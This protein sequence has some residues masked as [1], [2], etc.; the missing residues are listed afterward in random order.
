MVTHVASDVF[1]RTSTPPPPS[2]GEGSQRFPILGY[3]LLMSIPFDV[4]QPISA[5]YGEGRVI[6]GQKRPRHKRTGPHAYPILGNSLLIPTWLTFSA[7]KTTIFA[8]KIPVSLV[9]LFNAL[10]EGGSPWNIV[11]AL[12]LQKN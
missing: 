11:T 1:V 7:A 9:G 10:A 4:E 8:K 2:Q 12:R 5:W 3:I 6:R